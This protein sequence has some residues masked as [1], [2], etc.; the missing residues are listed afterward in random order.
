MGRPEDLFTGEKKA[1]V[2]ALD[3]KIR[4]ERGLV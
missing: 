1:N 2:C 3:A 4:M